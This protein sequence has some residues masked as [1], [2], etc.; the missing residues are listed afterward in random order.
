LSRACENSLQ[1][2]VDS[3]TRE[4]E[5]DTARVLHV[6]EGLMI[7]SLPS[8]ALG[9]IDLGQHTAG[10]FDGNE[11]GE[12]A[13]YPMERRSAPTCRDSGSFQTTHA[14]PDRIV[15]CRS[16]G[17]GRPKLTRPTTA[18]ITRAWHGQPAQIAILL[19]CRHLK[20]A[21]PTRSPAAPSPV[22][23]AGMWPSLYVGL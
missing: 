8:R 7:A 21:R 2:R 12:H 10:R 14:A 17:T 19:A 3:R 13:L 22:Q 1:R 23:G 18:T 4:Q 15:R 6:A 5:T 16:V 9:R 11:D 20:P